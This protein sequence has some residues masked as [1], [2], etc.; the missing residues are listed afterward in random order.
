[1]TM[2]IKRPAFVLPIDKL[3][4]VFLKKLAARFSR[5]DSAFAPFGHV[6]SFLVLS[7]SLSFSF[8]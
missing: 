8:A 6:F 2:V 4:P 5:L 7:G 1:M 3:I